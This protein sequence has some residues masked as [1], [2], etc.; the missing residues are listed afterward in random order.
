MLRTASLAILGVMVATG[1]QLLL[2]AGMERV[3]YIGAR[4]V[5][6]PM[7]LAIQVASEPRVLIGLVLFVISAG[8]WLIVLSRIPLSLAYPFAGLTYVFVT[9]FS[10]FVLNEEVPGIRWLGLAL[11]V[12]GI[13]LVGRS[14]PPGLE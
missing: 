4:Q 9:V 11:I 12:G 7:K 10:K 6:K 8:V 13:F 2:R 3:G 5:A 1:G 14:A